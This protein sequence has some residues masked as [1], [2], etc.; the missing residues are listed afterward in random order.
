[1]RFIQKTFAVASRSLGVAFP[2]QVRDVAAHLG[3]DYSHFS[4]HTL[5]SVRNALIFLRISFKRLSMAHLQKRAPQ[6]EKT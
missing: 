3:F 6:Q 1:V 5:I 2:R 4:A